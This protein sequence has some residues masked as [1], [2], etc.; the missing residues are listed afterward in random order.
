[1]R[2]KKHI[3][4]HS[5]W[6]LYNTYRSLYSWI[7]MASNLTMPAF[8][9]CL[10]GSNSVSL[11]LMIKFKKKSYNPQW[12][13]FFSSWL[14]YVEWSIL[15]RGNVKWHSNTWESA[16]CL[17]R[18]TRPVNASSWAPSTHHCGFR[19]CPANEPKKACLCW[20]CFVVHPSEVEGQGWPTSLAVESPISLSYCF[21]SYL[22]NPT[23]ENPSFPFFFTFIFDIINN[24]FT[25]FLATFFFS[26]L[27]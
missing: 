20:A 21:I 12:S 18:R 23:P 25:F 19:F 15:A 8:L 1:M 5:E 6:V 4:I 22:A 7:Y 17:I 3:G 9:P 24:P 13:L 2:Y 10:I 14:K 11:A 16:L 26:Y 27:P